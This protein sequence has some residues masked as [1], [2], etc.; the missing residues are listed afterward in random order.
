[1]PGI[2]QEGLSNIFQNST[3]QNVTKES[4]KTGFEYARA[5]GTQTGQTNV[6]QIIIANCLTV[7]NAYKAGSRLGVSIIHLNRGGSVYHPPFMCNVASLSCS[8]AAMGCRA[9]N[10]LRPM[11]GLS[12]LADGL[13]ICGDVMAKGGGEERP[14]IRQMLM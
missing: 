3:F 5:Q 8:F 6:L 1:M 12:L 9:A 2:I 11:G 13:S 7:K 4:V 10:K 14:T